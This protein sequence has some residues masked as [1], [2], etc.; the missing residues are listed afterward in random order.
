MNY[1]SIITQVYNAIQSGKVFNLP[2]IRIENSAEFD[3]ALLNRSDLSPEM[4]RKIVITIFAN[5]ERVAKEILQQQA[6]NA[7]VVSN[8]SAYLGADTPIFQK[9]FTDAQI[10]DAKTAYQTAEAVLTNEVNKLVV[11]KKYEAIARKT[12]DD[13]CEGF[14]SSKSKRE[15]LHG[16]WTQAKFNREKQESVIAT[17]RVNS[18]KLKATYDEMIR[19]NSDYLAQQTR[20]YEEQRRRQEAEREQARLEAELQQKA[21]ETQLTT[22]QIT[23]QWQ[24]L[25]N[26]MELLDKK[27]Q[28]PAPGTG[29]GVGVGASAGTGVGVGASAG[30]GASTATNVA[31]SAGASSSNKT[32]YIVLAVVAVLAVGG[33]LFYFMRKN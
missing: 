10:A 26:D 22:A 4:Q 14:C 2:F 11:L 18:A 30:T 12:Y 15:R 17:A 7:V 19:A 9:K 23:T 3:T 13:E 20:E 1:D 5:N 27:L 28:E 8:E 16:K 31:A 24:T 33:G 32:L 21:T 29:T 25:Q 6:D